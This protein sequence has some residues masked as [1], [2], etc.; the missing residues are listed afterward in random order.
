MQVS[1]AIYY[2]GARPFVRYDTVKPGEFARAVQAMR[3]AG[4]APYA[5][6]FEIEVEKFL[7]RAPGAWEQVGRSGRASLWRPRAEA[8]PPPAPASRSLAGDI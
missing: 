2:Y 5:L 3:A 1:G 7:A 4:A 8:P 6:L